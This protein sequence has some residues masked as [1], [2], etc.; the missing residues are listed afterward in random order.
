MK[1]NN[2]GFTLLETIVVITLIVAISIVSAVVFYNL[3]ERKS[4]EKDVDSV[5]SIID[6]TRKMSLNRKY[7]SAYGVLLST[8]SIISFSGNT[9]STGNKISEYSLDKNNTI[10]INLSSGTKE[11]DFK[12]VTGDLTA[13]GTIVV[14]TS[15]YSKIIT[16]YGTGL[17]ESK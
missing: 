14:G 3:K 13:T 5:V 1:K 16:I 17:I 2:K 8:T 9:Y 11:I 10:S 15:N 12:K 6:S 4:V 7:D